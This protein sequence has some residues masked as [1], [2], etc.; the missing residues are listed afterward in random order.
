MGRDPNEIQRS[1]AGSILIAET[2]NE[3]KKRI[4]R[5]VQ[6]RLQRLKETGGVSMSLADDRLKPSIA[7]TPEQCIEKI[8]AYVNAGA[9][10]FML[11]FT[12]ERFMEDLE[13]FAKQVISFFN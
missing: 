3:A 6:K 11:N 2:E 9:T 1:W 12:R 5:C 8:N 10:Q 7:G 13:L 4:E